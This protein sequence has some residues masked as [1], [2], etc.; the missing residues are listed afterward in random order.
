[1][2]GSQCLEERSG[3]SVKGSREREGIKGEYK[4]KRKVSKRDIYLT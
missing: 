1:M 4:K 3:G 2:Q